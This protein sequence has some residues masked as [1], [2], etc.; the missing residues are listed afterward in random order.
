VVE[1]VEEI[2]GLQ[3]FKKSYLAFLVKTTLSMLVSLSLNSNVME[4][5]K[6]GSMQTRQLSVKSSTSAPW[7]THRGD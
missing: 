2:M 6:E 5:S 4:G 7:L 1:G 3:V